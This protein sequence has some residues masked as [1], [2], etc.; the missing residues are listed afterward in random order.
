MNSIGAGLLPLAALRMG[1]KRREVYHT[2]RRRATCRALLGTFARHALAAVDAPTGA[3]A[4]TCRPGPLPPF[5]GDE[6]TRSAASR[7]AARSFRAARWR[8][9]RRSAAAVEDDGGD[10]APL[11]AFVR[12]ALVAVD[13]PGGVAGSTCRPWPPPA[14]SRRRGGALGGIPSAGGVSIG[15]LISAEINL[16]VGGGRAS[17]GTGRG[18][19]RLVN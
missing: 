17:K 10:R 16:P 9:R 15:K 6:R 4:S 1:G 14:P 7:P 3:A 8:L 18:T 2:R 19:A 5:H 12:A 11:G 13:V